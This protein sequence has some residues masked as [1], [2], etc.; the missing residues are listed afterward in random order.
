MAVSLGNDIDY[1]QMF[2]KE[3][4][5]SARKGKE[6]DKEV[7]ARLV[8]EDSAR[9]SLEFN[10]GQ[11]RR[12]NDNPTMSGLQFTPGIDNVYKSSSVGDSANIRILADCVDGTNKYLRVKMV[13]K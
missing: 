6:T 12:S 7:A 10:I 2:S 13:D 4:L 5:K 11:I 9:K 8:F 1:T 3:A